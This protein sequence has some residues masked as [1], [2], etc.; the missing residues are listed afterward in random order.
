M[1]WVSAVVFTLI[2]FVLAALAASMGPPD[3][4]DPWL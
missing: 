1:D 2:V 4:F 3:R